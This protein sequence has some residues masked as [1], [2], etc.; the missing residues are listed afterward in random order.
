MLIRDII[1]YQNLFLLERNKLKFVLRENKLNFEK[2]KFH[3]EWTFTSKK[4]QWVTLGE[5]W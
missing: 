1:L 2:L 4:F 3:M 5:E